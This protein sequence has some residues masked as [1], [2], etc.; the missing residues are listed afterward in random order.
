MGFEVDVSG[1]DIFEKDYTVMVAET[2]KSGVILGHKFSDKNRKIIRAKHGQRQYRYAVSKKG[3]ANLRVRLYCI[4]IYC[5]FRELKKRHGLKKVNLDVCRDFSGNEAQI[6][7]NLNHFTGK[8]LK[9]DIRMQFVALPKEA[10][11]DKYAFLVRHDKLN[12]LAKLCVPIKL[13]E[14]ERFLK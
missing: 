9:I 2:G 12:K 6:K 4:T 14:F 5:I 13:E 8:L 11:A 10:A 7:I 1:P 3:K